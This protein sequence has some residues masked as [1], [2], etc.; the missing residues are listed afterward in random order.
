MKKFSQYIN[1][2]EDCGCGQVQ[3]ESA[4][5]FNAP[6]S[7][8]GYA[9]GMAVNATKTFATGLATGVLGKGAEGLHTAGK[10]GDEEKSDKV[11]A[12]KLQCK[13]KSLGLKRQLASQTRTYN[14]ADQRCKTT[15]NKEDCDDAARY[16]EIVNDTQ[17]EIKHH[18]AEC[19]KVQSAKNMHD[20]TRARIAGQQKRLQDLGGTP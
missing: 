12:S 17:E 9:S 2:Q 18:E 8:S 16:E 7:K 20:V 14:N 4:I 13:E 1:S 11:I 5:S 15:A 3:E 19:N 10:A 6:I